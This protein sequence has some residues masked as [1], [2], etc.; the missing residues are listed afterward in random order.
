MLCGKPAATQYRAIIEGDEP[1][2]SA[3]QPV[4]LTPKD[5]LSILLTSA[6]RKGR[7]R[8]AK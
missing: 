6:L 4:K 3:N 1:Y 8:A 5:R 7:Q 2:L